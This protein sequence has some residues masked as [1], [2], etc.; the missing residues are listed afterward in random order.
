LFDLGCVRK[1]RR[2]IIRLCSILQVPVINEYTCQHISQNDHQDS[3]NEEQGQREHD[4]EKNSWGDFNLL[5]FDVFD[6]YCW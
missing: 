3:P 2:R 5:S 6:E 4:I 1:P